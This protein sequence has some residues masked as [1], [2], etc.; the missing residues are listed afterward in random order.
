MLKPEVAEFA[1]F[2]KPEMLA[3]MLAM[4]DTV[5]GPPLKKPEDGSVVALKKPVV[6]AMLTNV[7]SKGP[8]LA[9]AGILIAVEPPG[10][11]MLTVIAGP[12]PVMGGRTALLIAPASRWGSLR[13]RW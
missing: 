5:P 13:C 8:T 1:T 4:P 3:P 2:W 6:A 10:S 11:P 7:T 9:V 12:V